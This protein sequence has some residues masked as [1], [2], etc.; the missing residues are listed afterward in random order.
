MLYPE[1]SGVD[2]FV[3]GGRSRC[4]ISSPAVVDVPTDNF[5]NI[6][7]RPTARNP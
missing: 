2:P 5:Q 6:H 7:V 3:E 1:P 4:L